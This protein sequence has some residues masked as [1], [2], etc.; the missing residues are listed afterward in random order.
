MES[1]SLVRV[2]AMIRAF[3]VPSRITPAGVG[4]PVR[5]LGS[6]ITR[7]MAGAGAVP[8]ALVAMAATIAAA[9]TISAVGAPAAESALP[10]TP[11]VGAVAVG[12]IIAPIGPAGVATAVIARTVVATL[13]R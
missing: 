8:S 2:P 10:G 7:I 1:T 12:P 3:V 6:G 5:P 4:A 9:T 11:L 13:P